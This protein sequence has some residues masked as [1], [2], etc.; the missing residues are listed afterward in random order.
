VN[1]ELQRGVLFV[2]TE[3][4]FKCVNYS[5]KCTSS[6]SSSS[7]SLLVTW[8]WEAIASEGSSIEG[9]IDQLQCCGSGEFTVG[10]LG[11]FVG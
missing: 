5:S 8:V 2:V 4:T 3:I 7:S 11:F 9:L 10:L 1:L 6:S